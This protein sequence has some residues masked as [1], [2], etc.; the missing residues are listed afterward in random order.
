MYSSRE[1]KNIFAIGD[2]TTFEIEYRMKK[3][4]HS[5]LLHTR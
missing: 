3:Y 2:K 5:N 1:E 4:K